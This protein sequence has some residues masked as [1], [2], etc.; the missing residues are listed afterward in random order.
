MATLNLTIALPPTLLLPLL[1]ASM[2]LL[3]ATRQMGLRWA[4]WAAFP[5]LLLAIAT[6]D[7]SLVELPWL[8]LGSRFAIDDTGRLFLL[9][10]AMLWLAAGFYARGY[11]ASDPRRH[12]FT[13][14]FLVG[15]SG[16]LGVCLAQDAASFYFAFALMTFAAYGLVVHERHAEAQR[17]GR[18]YL[19]MAVLGEAALIAGL[20]L[21]AASAQTHLLPEMTLSAAADAPLL[22]YALLFVGFG[23][24]AGVPCLHMWLPLAHPVAPTPASAVLSGAMIKAGLLGWL[25]FLPLGEVAVPALGTLMLSLGLFATFFGV[26]IGLL[27]RQ[28]K[29]LLAYSSISQMGFMTLA[30]GAGLLLPEAWPALLPAVGL[31]ALQHGLAKGALFLGLGVAQ[32]YSRQGWLIAGLLLPAL[33]L[34]GAPFTS[35][36]L[37]KSELKTALSGLPSFWPE[38]LAS[39]LPLAA[40]GTGLL[41]A[42]FLLKTPYGSQRD[43]GDSSDRGDDRV[44]L[45]LPWLALL[46]AMLVLTWMH[47]DAGT[48]AAVFSSQGLQSTVWPAAVAALVAYTAWR[49]DWRG[50]AIPP[51]DVLVWL[52]QAATLPRVPAA[53]RR[54][55]KTALATALV[56]VSRIRRLEETL[57]SW[58]LAGALWLLALGALAAALLAT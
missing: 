27:Q 19:I 26:A 23:V 3:P 9:F 45:L 42:R 29:T 15:L 7:A 5:G 43:Q 54:Q 25:R 11:L 51:G 40:V 22:A 24:K 30:V 52:E 31:Y 21:L 50:P 46:A 13:A 44:K 32:R 18:I 36:A 55:S 38:L 56:A 28:P 20:L 1:L 41:M 47:A 37:A 58:P 10:S 8:L 6:P 2:V 53:P 57:R 35:G 49:A 12:V 14:F 17:A 33:A 16:N 48:V 39:A 34:A 4:P